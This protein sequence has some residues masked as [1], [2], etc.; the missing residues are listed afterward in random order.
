MYDECYIRMCV[1]EYKEEEIYNKHNFMVN[2]A[3]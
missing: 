2:N 1:N 3:I